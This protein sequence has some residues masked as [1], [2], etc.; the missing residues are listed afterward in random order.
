MRQVTLI[1]FRRWQSFLAGEL[2]VEQVFIPSDSEANPDCAR[3]ISVLLSLS[4]TPAVCYLMPKLLGR[5]GTNSM[6]DS[7]LGKSE[8]LPGLV[9]FEAIQRTATADN[10]EEVTL[11]Q[12]QLGLR[13]QSE[14]VP[15][16]ARAKHQHDV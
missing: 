2:I 12:D 5:E 9:A 13:F 11:L 7:P 14:L 8:R 10:H 4:A 16:I 15:A 3:V 6:P 1:L